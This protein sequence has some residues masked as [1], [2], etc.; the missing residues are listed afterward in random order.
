MKGPNQM[1]VTERQRG[2][3]HPLRGQYAAWPG[4]AEKA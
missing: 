3:G 2:S 1:R 4:N